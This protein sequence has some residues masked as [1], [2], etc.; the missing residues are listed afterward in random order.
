MYV[1]LEDKFAE[2]CV[3]TVAKVNSRLLDIGG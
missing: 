1:P 2:I 3:D